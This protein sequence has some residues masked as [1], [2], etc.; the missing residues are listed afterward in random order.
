MIKGMEDILDIDYYCPY[1]SAETTF[2]LTSC[3]NSLST[4]WRN[5]FR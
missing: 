1:L 5:Y 4:I 3:L 2:H